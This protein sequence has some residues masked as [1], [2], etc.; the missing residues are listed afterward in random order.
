MAVLVLWLGLLT[1]V[2]AAARFYLGDV[3]IESCPGFGI[4]FVELKLV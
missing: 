4:W 1:V 2:C 3:N